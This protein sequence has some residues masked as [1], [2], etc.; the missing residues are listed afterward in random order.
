MRHEERGMSKVQRFEDLRAWQLAMDLNDRI[1][2]LTD[3]PEL[4][5]DFPLRDQM[6]RASISVPSNIAEGFER[7]TRAQ[8]HHFLS[9]AKAS[10]AELRTQLYVVVRV[11]KVDPEHV[12]QIHVLAEQV[13]RTVGKLRMTV[14]Q[15]RDT[16]R[17]HTHASSP[18]PHA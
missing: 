13:A 6:R 11:K 17:T 7:G 10:C 12:S 2:E 9:I 5:H 1:Y 4:H 3:M 15:Q 16:P 8:F 18:M 14:E